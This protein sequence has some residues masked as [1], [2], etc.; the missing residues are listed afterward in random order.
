MAATG[1]ARTVTVMSAAPDLWSHPLTRR[2]WSQLAALLDTAGVEQDRVAAA[3]RYAAAAHGMQLRRSGAP[4]VTHPLEV[5]ALVADVGGTSAMIVAALL[6][7]VLEDTAVTADE[8]RARFGDEVASLVEGATKVAAVHPA[9]GD[10]ARQAARLRKMF[11]ALA[12]DPRVV[13]IKL[14]D[15]LHNLR[16]ISYLEPVKAARI[17]A[18]TL[19]V[20]A[21]LA[22]RLGLGAMKAEL[23]D[24]AFAAADPDAFAAIDAQLAL[25]GGRQERLAAA[26][27]ELATVLGG[28]VP[29]AEVS[30]RIKHRWSVHRKCVR[31]RCAPQELSDLLGLR[32]VVGTLEECYAALS[33]VHRRWEPLPGRFKDY[34]QRPKFNG[35]RSVHTTVRLADGTT[36]EVQVRTREMHDAAEHGTAAHHLYKSSASEPRWL[37]RLLEWDTSSDSDD[38]Y[39]DGV[40]GELDA[41]DE[42]LVLTPGGDVIAL[43]PG[44][45]PVDFAYAVHTD[46]GNRCVGAKVDGRLVPLTSPLAGGARVEIVTGDRDGPALEWLDSAVT[47]KARQRV[48]QFHARRLRAAAHERGRDRLR[49][50]ARELRL[51]VRDDETLEREAWELSGA[52]SVGDML[53]Q[54]A[55][56][57]LDASRLLRPLLPTLSP[58]SGPH[59]QPMSTMPPNSAM[60]PVPAVAVPAGRGVRVPAAAG[61]AGVELRLA[62]CCRPSERDALAGVV[63]RLGVVVHA[64]SCPQGRSLLDSDPGRAVPV[65]WVGSGQVAE[66]VRV[67]VPPRAG[68]LFELASRVA[69]AGGEL[70]AS[71]RLSPGEVAL[72]VAFVPARRRDLRAALALVAGVTVRR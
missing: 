28:C 6:H 20:H 15:R 46:L 18:E 8:L 68:L 29:S 1:P 55:S 43:P 11:V 2:S 70:L 3:A 59:A 24:L 69:S 60:P 39:L 13:V 25:L 57:R 37:A 50:A 38:D 30:G 16:T 40:R 22:H 27:D 32:V 48:R 44:A 67:T 42:L 9:A 34:V 53:E 45:T 64:A 5:A 54:V 36:L 71:E 51:R 14:C 21:P 19:A 4:Y 49:R 31:Q 58:P 35:Y 26:R 23:E 47:A 56:G 66:V 72:T 10:A 33:E 12:Q 65:F 41:R 62:G 61:L 17:G 7:D 63:A 52:P